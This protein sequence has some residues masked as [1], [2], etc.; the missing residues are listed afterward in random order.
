MK[1]D[2]QRIAAALRKRADTF[3][4]EFC[5]LVDADT[6]KRLTGTEIAEMIDAGDERVNDF[7]DDVVGAAIT[8]IRVR[9]KRK[10]E[11]P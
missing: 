9:A 8:I 5:G 3:G 10:K 6:G 7:I 2:G 1:T 11:N 4:D